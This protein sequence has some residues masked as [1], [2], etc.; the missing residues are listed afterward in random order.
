[1]LFFIEDTFKTRG[2]FIGLQFSVLS[3]K[4]SVGWRVEGPQ[5]LSFF[6]VFDVIFFVSTLKTLLR[7][8]VC[9]SGCS[10]RFY[11]NIKLDGV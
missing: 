4:E 5:V 7:H 6:F 1:M 8:E 10:F 11:L 2:L 3:Q 9:S